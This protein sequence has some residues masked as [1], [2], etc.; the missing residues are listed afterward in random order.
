ME[1]K[2]MAKLAR[3]EKC[4]RQSKPKALQK[5]QAAGRKKMVLKLFHEQ[6]PDGI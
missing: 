4:L 1:A 6:C 5:P 3:S 2:E